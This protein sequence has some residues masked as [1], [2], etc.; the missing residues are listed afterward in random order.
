MRAFGPGQHYPL[1]QTPFPPPPSTAPLPSDY[2][3]ES[4]ASYTSSPYVPQQSYVGSSG[5]TFTLTANTVFF[6]P[7]F[8]G[9]LGRTVT[10]MGLR[11]T[12]V[13]TL[14]AGVKM[15]IYSCLPASRY[16]IY[17]QALVASITVNFTATTGRQ[18][19]SLPTPVELS[20]GLY[21]VAVGRTSN[22]S[23]TC[24]ANATTG[25]ALTAERNP[26][27]WNTTGSGYTRLELTLPQASPLPVDDGDI[28]DA[29]GLT[30]VS[31]NSPQVEMA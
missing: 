14:P 6:L 31:V 26:L 11:L 10:E 2:W 20:N 13:P 29:G 19:A 27:Q 8:V 16:D 23:V 17:P 1:R 4:N 21:W 18:V 22:N 28:V 15:G 7:F 9:R 5:G 24:R 30:P 3:H 25:F 12:N